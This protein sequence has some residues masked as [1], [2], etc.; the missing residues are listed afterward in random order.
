MSSVRGFTAKAA[1]SSF[2]TRA[3]A[4]P[5]STSSSNED[6]E[7]EEENDILA[8][9]KTLISNEVWGADWPEY[10]QFLALLQSQGYAQPSLEYEPKKFLFKL[11]SVTSTEAGLKMLTSSIMRCSFLPNAFKK[12]C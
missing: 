1:T 4:A 11:Q 10:V 7:D 6:D 9:T 2:R 12:T 8:A 5:F 3:A